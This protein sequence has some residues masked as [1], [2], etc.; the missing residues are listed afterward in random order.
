MGNFDFIIIKAKE[1]QSLLKKELELVSFKKKIMGASGLE[2][3]VA[4]MGHILD[5]VY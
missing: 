2:E 1:E 5:R 4:E 3:V